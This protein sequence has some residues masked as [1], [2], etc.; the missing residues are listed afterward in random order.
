MNFHHHN[1]NHSHMP[2]HIHLIIEYTCHYYI[3]IHQSHMDHL[4]CNSRNVIRIM[5]SIYILMLINKIKTTSIKC[6]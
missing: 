5:K 4:K 6:F 3:G 2:H 1:Y